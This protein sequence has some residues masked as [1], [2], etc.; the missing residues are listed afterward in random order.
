MSVTSQPLDAPIAPPLENHSDAEHRFRWA[1]RAVLLLIA[2]AALQ[3]RAQDLN[4]STGYMDETVYVLYG[5][6][7]LTGNFEEPL[8]TPLR[9]SY[10]WYLWPVLAATAEKFGGIPA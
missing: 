7:F 1:R 2:A 6:M 9:W 8:D 5:R 4:F 3:V 10:G